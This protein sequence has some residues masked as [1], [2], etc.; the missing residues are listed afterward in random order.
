MIS[1]GSLSGR[2]Q[3]QKA[4]REERPANKGRSDFEDHYYCK[5]IGILLNQVSPLRDWIVLQWKSNGLDSKYCTL[6]D[7]F[8]KRHFSSYNNKQARSGLIPD[9]A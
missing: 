7:F 4:G 9:R 3:K 2:I 8:Y 1:S 5:E 6:C